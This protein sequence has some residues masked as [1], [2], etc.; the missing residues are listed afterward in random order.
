MKQIWILGLFLVT[1]L[2]SAQTVTIT[3]I[4]PHKIEDEEEWFEFSVEADGLVDMSNW[5]VSNTKSTKTFFEKKGYL[6]IPET[7]TGSGTSYTGS[8]LVADSS[9]LLVEINGTA[10]FYWTKSPVSLANG[11][12]TVQILDGDKNLLDKISY[13]DTKSGTSSGEKYAEIWNRKN[14]SEVFPLLY[15][16]NDSSLRHSRGTENFSYPAS[17]QDIELLIS[18]IS[19]DRDSEKGNEF[20]ELFVKSTTDDIAN[21]KYLEVKHNGT[22]LIYV[23]HDFEVEE[24]DFVV[25]KLDENQP[26]VTRKT[27]P[28]Q[29]S[30]NKRDGISAG[31]GTIE[32]ILYSG[33]SLEDTEDF[34]CW[35]DGDLSQTESNRVDKNILAENWSGDCIDISKLISNESIGRETTYPDTN[36]KN[37]FFRHFNGSEGLS[38]DIQNQAP[39]AQIEVQ[40]GKKI[41]KGY[42]NFTGDKSSDPDGEKDLE[43]YEWRVNGKTCPSET[44]TWHWYK[45]CEEQFKKINPDKIYFDEVGIYAISLTVTDFS[46]AIDTESVE[47]EVTESGID[48]FGLSSAGSAGSS[49]FSKSIE[50][51]LEQ[52]LEDIPKNKSSKTVSLSEEDHFF[53]NFIASQNQQSNQNQEVV[54]YDF[55][56]ENIEPPPFMQYE[57]F[58]SD[59]KSRIKKNI[60]FIFLE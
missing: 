28:H 57:K 16:T 29:I 9:D 36:T 42:L 8:G 4:A 27:N 60:G 51:W 44:A 52:E 20:I 58:D 46:G 49:A 12:G 13:P 6:V 33:T 40:G 31:S 32:V 30:T 11:G 53:D 5:Q 41:F 54:N 34:I 2:A 47:I 37:D 48:P 50:K 3:E 18:E 24:G 22:P 23:D 45:D 38:N 14:Q 15:R 1:A 55:L 21:L 43:S 59:Q 56:W 19:P 26:S 39:I 35:K 10:I 7:Y 17:V 25:L